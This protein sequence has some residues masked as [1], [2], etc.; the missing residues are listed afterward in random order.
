MGQGSRFEAFGLVF[1]RT[2]IGWHFLYE[3]YYKLMLPGWSRGGAPLSHWSAAGYLQ[4]ST[5]PFAGLAHLLASPSL[6][7][8]LDMI[9][10]LGL[11]LVGVSLVLGLFTQ[12]GA[13]GAL[14]FLTLFYL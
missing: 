14:A 8:W 11:L 5:G 2:V 9:V 12:L 4:A 3:G 10:P 1:L 13:W 7:A 6:L